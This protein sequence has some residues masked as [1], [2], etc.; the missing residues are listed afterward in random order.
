MPE[1][2]MLR[3]YVLLT[4]ERSLSF[5][6]SSWSQRTLGF[7]RRQMAGA[8]E[9][10]GAGSRVCTDIHS[11]SEGKASLFSGARQLLFATADGST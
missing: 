6:W 3:G 1:P 7:I 8:D 11:G 10:L 5:R 4:Q 2:V 9:S